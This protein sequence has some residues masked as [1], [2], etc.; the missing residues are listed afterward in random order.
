MT[1]TGSGRLW[2]WWAVV[3]SP[4][5][6]VSLVP[7]VTETLFTLGLG[8]SIVGVT[9]YCTEPREGVESK[10]KVGGSKDPK[11]D[12]IRSL[13][14]DLVVANVEENSKEHVEQLREWGIPV[15]VTY[16]RT[17]REGIEMIRELGTMTG[18]EDRAEAIIQE[19]ESLYRQAVNLSKTWRPAQVFYPVWRNPYMTVNRD[20]YINDMLTVCGGMNVFADRPERYPEVTLDEMAAALPE[21]ILLPDEPY[22]FRKAHVEDFGRY[23]DVPAVREGRIYLVDGKLFCWYGPRIREALQT[24]PSLLHF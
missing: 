9:A 19:I 18:A 21:V 20:T 1:L 15:F 6:I 13:E 2:Y 7:S 8:N 23:P 17:V 10:I 16:P 4:R 5:R 3:H 12:L 11:L 22:R 14:P 24:V